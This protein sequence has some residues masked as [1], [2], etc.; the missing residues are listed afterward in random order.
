LIA[1]A[2]LAR[3]GNSDLGHAAL[4]EDLDPANPLDVFYGQEVECRVVA[5]LAVVD[6]AEVVDRAGD[7]PGRVDAKAPLAVPAHR[8]DLE[9][10]DLFHSRAGAA[11][12][13]ELEGA[14]VLQVDPG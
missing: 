4:V 9:H 11:A 10:L 7:G 12:V 5:V 8:A 1:G 2:T 13:F 3:S 14:P 6:V